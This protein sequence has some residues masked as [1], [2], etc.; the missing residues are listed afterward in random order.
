[1]MDGRFPWR[2]GL[3][4]L[5]GVLLAGC[6]G[7]GSNASPST[8][9]LAPSPSPTERTTP[10]LTATPSPTIEQVVSQAYLRYWQ[11]Y[12]DALFNLDVSRLGEVMTGPELE[13]ARKEIEAL[14]QRGRAAKI[15]VEHNFF[16]A[17]LN[18]NTGS[19]TI[20]DD[21]SN[22]SYEVDAETK[23]MIGQPA[24]GTKISD[25]YFLVVEGGTWKVRDGIRQGS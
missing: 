18:S 3:L 9:T 6:G 22:R 7:G 15:A 13:G 11:V 14:R 19:A 5:M 16:I 17:D 12:S 2:V 20:H 1:M 24:P 4:V 8:A 21:Y 23:Q 10:G 25:T